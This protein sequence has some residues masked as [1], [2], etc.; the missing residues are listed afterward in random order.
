MKGLCL[1]PER[2]EKVVAGNWKYCEWLICNLFFALKL[3]YHNKQRELSWASDFW[4]EKGSWKPKVVTS[5]PSFTRPVQHVLF[6]IL[7]GVLEISILEFGAT[8]RPF[9]RVTES[10]YFNLNASPTMQVAVRTYALNNHIQ[11]FEHCASEIKW[12]LKQSM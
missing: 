10:S 3:H 6:E 4:T 5:F 7:F 2:C 1:T 8:V 9:C 11:Y 12:L